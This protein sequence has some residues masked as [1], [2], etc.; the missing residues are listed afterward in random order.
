MLCVVKLRFLLVLGIFLNI[1]LHCQDYDLTVVGSAVFSD[2][3]GRQSIALIDMLKNDLR[4]NF[5][6]TKKIDPADVSEEIKA[7]LF[8]PD[9]TPGGVSIL[10]DPLWYIF[11]N[12]P[13][14][15]WVPNSQIKIAYS[16]LESSKIPSKWVQILNTKFDAVVV[17]DPYLAEVYRKCGVNIPIFE[18]PLP[19]YLDEFLKHKHNRSSGRFTFGT[20]SSGTSRKNNEL[21]IRAF[22]EEFGNANNVELLIHCRYFLS[23]SFN[24]L[25]SYIRSFGVKNIILTGNSLTQSEYVDLLKKFDCLVRIS[26]GE[27]FSIPPREALAMGIPCILSNNTA[28]KTLCDSGLVLA[29][30]SIIEEPAE[31]SHFFGSQDAGF[32]YNCKLDDVKA[33]LREMYTN[34][35]VYKK[36][37]AKGPQWV[38]QCAFSQLKK[39]YLSL[40]KPQSV[41]FGDR[42]AID[43]SYLMT[44]S[45]TLYEKY[46]KLLQRQSDLSE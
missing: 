16:M 41:I 9:Q 13:N 28:Q 18:I 14:Y 23:E 6:P 39:K 15:R 43:D 35:P 45:L 26:K 37:A 34:Y 1:S 29:V 3:I 19:L 11:H 12:P 40:I 24:E 2:G 10:E 17:P 7:I 38:G 27:G 36:K 20:T 25:Q 31:Y 8:N 44:N 4:V 42:N 46:C 33:A 32:F 22:A 5:I 30:R 21:L